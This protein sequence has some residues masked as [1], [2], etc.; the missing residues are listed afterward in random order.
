MLA[1]KEYKTKHDWVVKVIHW[2]KF[3]FNHTNKKPNP[4]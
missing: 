4:S 1:Q 2:E 3:R